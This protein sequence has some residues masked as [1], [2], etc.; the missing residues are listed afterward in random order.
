MKEE[1]FFIKIRKW[2]LENIMLCNSIEDISKIF[3][4]FNGKLAYVL[5]KIENNKK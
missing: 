2:L 4:I 5:Y 3:D 1:I